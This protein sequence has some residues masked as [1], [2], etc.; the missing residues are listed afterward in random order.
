MKIDSR[1]LHMT[2]GSGGITQPR[3]IG[4]LQQ[5]F[6]V[7]CGKPQGWVTP[8]EEGLTG[9]VYV[10][11]NCEQVRGIPPLRRANLPEPKE[12]P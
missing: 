7:N 10:C 11:R 9:V 2:L 8:P 6:C 5:V 1:V 4:G 3:Y 12:F